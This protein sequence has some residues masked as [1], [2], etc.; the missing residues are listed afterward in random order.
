MCLFSSSSI[1]PKLINAPH[2]QLARATTEPEFAY[3]AAMLTAL[4]QA[5]DMMYDIGQALLLSPTYTG[6]GALLTEG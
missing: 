5:R 6:P 1:G 2:W 3:G 4:K